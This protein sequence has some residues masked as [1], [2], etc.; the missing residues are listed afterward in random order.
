MRYKLSVR[1]LEILDKDRIKILRRLR[2]SHLDSTPSS[3]PVKSSTKNKPMKPPILVVPLDDSRLFCI[4]QKCSEYDDEPKLDEA[5]ENKKLNGTSSPKECCMKSRDRK[6]GR[7]KVMKEKIWGGEK[8]IVTTEDKCFIDEPGTFLNN[9]PTTY[10]KI[11][12]ANLGELEVI[13]K[14]I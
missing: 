5:E 13:C 12:L 3:K 14:I 6:T 2:D 7:K 8:S 9:V 1:E 11:S 4:I 10:D